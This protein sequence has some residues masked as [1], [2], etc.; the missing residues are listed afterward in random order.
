PVVL[1]LGGGIAEADDQSG[2]GHGARGGLVGTG[3][4]VYAA[5]RP[6]SP[7][8]YFFAGDAGAAPGAAAAA[9]F[10]SSSLLSATVPITITAVAITGSLPVGTTGVTPFGILTAL[11]C[12][13]W[14]S[15]MLP[16]STSR[17]LGRSAGRQLT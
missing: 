8:A 11:R 4:P 1:V 10:S 6:G 12:I 9:A 2:R 5:G 15:V 16:R 7:A 17:K 3:P 13:D 14:S